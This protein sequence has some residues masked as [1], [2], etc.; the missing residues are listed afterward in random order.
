MSTPC[1]SSPFIARPC[2]RIQNSIQVRTATANSAAIPSRVSW[3][4]IGSRPTVSATTSSPTPTDSANAS[5]TPIQTAEPVAPADL[6]EVRRDDADDER[7]LE[8]LAEQQEERGGHGRGYLGWPGLRP[9]S[10][11]QGAMPTRCKGA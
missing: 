9:G 11:V 8:A 2:R 1:S 4:A 6:H 10:V 5:P 7:G 3:T